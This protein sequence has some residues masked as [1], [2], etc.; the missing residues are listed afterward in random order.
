[1]NHVRWEVQRDIPEPTEATAKA[2]FLQ[3]LEAKTDVWRSLAQYPRGTP[4]PFQKPPY[5]PTNLIEYLQ[6]QPDDRRLP[7]PEQQQQLQLPTPSDVGQTQDNRQPWNRS[8]KAFHK[9]ESNIQSASTKLD[10]SAVNSEVYHVQLVYTPEFDNTPMQELY[11]TCEGPHL[12]DHVLPNP[13]PHNSHEPYSNAPL[14]ISNLGCNPKSSPDTSSEAP[15]TTMRTISSTASHN[16]ECTREVYIVDDLQLVGI[17][18]L[19]PKSSFA[20]F[21]ARV[22]CHGLTITRHLAFQVL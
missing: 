19:G 20:V 8:Q 22:A 5:T 12:Q 17:D 1:M 6:Q 10:K 4:P 3:Q 13:S 15:P 2:Y 14:L 11:E 21:T 9:D 16:T 18:I 7:L